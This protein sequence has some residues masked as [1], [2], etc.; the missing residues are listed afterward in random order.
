MKSDSDG[1]K[2]C[3]VESSRERFI[4]PY[5]HLRRFVRRCAGPE[6]IGR[7]VIL[8]LA[9]RPKPS[10]T[11]PI[12]LSSA[13]HLLQI[14]EPGS[15]QQCQDGSQRRFRLTGEFAL[16]ENQQSAFMSREEGQYFLVGSGGLLGQ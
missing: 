11:R 2:L 4:C 1:A 12:S 7:G 8:K 10:I 3:A 16:A 5:H 6:R 15:H 9:I 13:P 14:S